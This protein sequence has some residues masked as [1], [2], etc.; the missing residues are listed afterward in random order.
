MNV[1][2]REMRAGLKPLVF[3]CLG[4][5]LFLA[6]SMQKFSVFAIDPASMQMLYE[7]PQALQDL[8]GIGYLDF[9]KASGF[10][11]M[12]YPYLMLMA[13]VHASMLGAVAVSKEERDKTAE[14]LYAKP[15]PRWAILTAKILAALTAAAIFNLVTWGASAAFIQSFGGEDMGGNLALLMTGLFILQLAYLSLG[16]AAATLAPKAGAAAGIATACMLATYFLSIAS[17]VSGK[18]GALRA[19]TPFKYFDARRIIGLGEGLDPAYV[20]LCLALTLALTTG[21]YLRFGRR[22]LKI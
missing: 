19:F 14:F 21:A 11:G 7:L 4:I 20:A 6:A 10:F 13:A 2:L 15:M 18:L 8:L 17:D 16:V 3:W 9:T 1:Y 12:M 22:D 5:G